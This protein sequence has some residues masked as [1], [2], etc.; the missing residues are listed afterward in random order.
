MVESLCVQNPNLKKILDT[1]Q[2]VKYDS[3]MLLQSSVRQCLYACMLETGK[4]EASVGRFPEKK[5]KKKL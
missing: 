2:S 1:N 3:V 5:K 4:S